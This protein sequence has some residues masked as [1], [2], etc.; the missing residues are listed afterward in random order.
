MPSS[1]CSKINTKPT[2]SR[3]HIIHIDMIDI[4]V[5]GEFKDVQI[6]LASNLNVYHIIDIIIVDSLEP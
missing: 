5:I 6:T 3:N 1:I 2:K 4:K